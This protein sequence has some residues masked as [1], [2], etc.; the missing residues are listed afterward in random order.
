MVALGAPESGVICTSVHIQK[1]REEEERAPLI[2]AALAVTAITTLVVLVETVAEVGAGVGVVTLEKLVTFKALAVVGAQ[3]KLL[4]VA[5]AV[6]DVG[7]LADQA[8]QETPE[9]RLTL[10]L[11]IA[12]M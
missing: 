2:P 5:V 4:A 8:V 7:V 6:A 12:L 11:L 9:A 10:P 3:A 1:V